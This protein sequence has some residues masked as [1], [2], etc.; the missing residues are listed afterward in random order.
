VS[1]VGGVFRSRLVL[2]RFRMLVEMEEGNQ[3]SPPAYGPAA[4]ALLEAYQT[5]GIHVKLSNVQEEKS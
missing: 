5:S 1:Y 2:E 3:V 4:G